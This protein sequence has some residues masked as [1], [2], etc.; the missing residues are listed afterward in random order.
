MATTHLRIVLTRNA[1]QDNEW[2]DEQTA[3]GR[4]SER[5]TLTEKKHEVT[6]KVCLKTHYFYPVKYRGRY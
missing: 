1:G 4:Q 3:C 5:N 6:C 2:S